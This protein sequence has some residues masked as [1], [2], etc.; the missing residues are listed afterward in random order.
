MIDEQQPALAL[1]H[2]L[3]IAGSPCA[4]KTS[5]ADAL[6][7][8]HAIPVYH[9]D[10]MERN[11][12][13]RRLARGNATR[14]VEF[15][16]MSMDQRWLEL[17]VAIMVQDAIESWTAR[18]PLVVEDILAMPN[19]SLIVAEGLFFPELLAPRL[20]SLH[21]AIWLVPTDAFCETIRR[22]RYAAGRSAANQTSN[23]EQALRK[24]I[25]RDQQL[26]RSMKQQAEAYHLPVYEV[27]GSRSLDAMTALVEQHVEPYIAGYRGSAKAKDTL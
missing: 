13:A 14:L 24:L 1:S 23:P 12:I 15:L 19:A 11:H 26:A 27:D 7:R 25:E 8:T 21:Q 9:F 22:Q 5:I 3:W 4:G 10:P 17:P 20:S 6:A 2:V 18:F 16:N